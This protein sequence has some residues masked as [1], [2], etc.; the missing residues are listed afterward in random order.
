MTELAPVD[1]SPFDSYPPAQ[2]AEKVENF[3]VAKAYLGTLQTILLGTLAGAFISFGATLFTPAI[4]DSVLGLGPTRLLDGITFLLGLV[5]VIIDGTELF[6]SNNLIIMDWADGQVLT[7]SLICNWTLVY[8][9]HF[10]GCL[11]TLVFVWFSDVL[12]FG[13]PG[14]SQAIAATTVRIAADNV[15]ITPAVT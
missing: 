10:I 13:R 6:M 3:G 1:Q 12:G 5:L 14:T 8:L 4:S 7:R 9:G 2:I 11:V 15:L